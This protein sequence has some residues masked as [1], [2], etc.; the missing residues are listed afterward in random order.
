MKRRVVLNVVGLT[1]RDLVGAVMPRLSVWAGKHSVSKIRPAFPAVTCTAQANYL[2]GKTP[3]EH[4]IV[5]NGWHD[6]ALGEVHFWK[7]SNRLVNAPKVWDVL[8]AKHPGLRVANLFWW[9]NMGSTVDIAVTPRPIYRADGSKF[10][11]VASYPQSLK[12]GLKAALGEFPFH[13]FWGP[14]AGI[15]ATQWIADSARWVEEKEKPDLSFVYLP[16][17]DYDLQ[18]FGPADERS[19][20]A[21]REMDV[22]VCDLIEFFEGRGVEVTV[23][24]EYGITAVDRAVPLNRVLRGKGW[25]EIKEERGCEV[26]DYMASKA[27]AVVDH[28]VAHISVQ[29]PSILLQ[30]KAL[31]EATPGVG[32]VLDARSQEAAGI[33]HSRSG[34]LVAVADDH[35][36]F[37]YPWWED[38]SKAPDYARTVDIHR[39]PGYDPCELFLDPTLPMPVLKIA[40]FLLKKKLGFKG[41][42]EVIP[43][44]ASLVRGSHGRVPEDTLDWPVLIGVGAESVGGEVASM[45]VFKVLVGS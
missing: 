26:L 13:T 6:R 31:L 1:A 28:Q 4:G 9:Y 45:E 35:S 7:Q 21:R 23:L 41:L 43:L 44:D 29:D 5:A 40:L 17:L 15:A 38:D 34:D 39:K 20:K 42:L 33:A 16:H 2:T 19:N 24:S 37:S 8:R 11:D 27:F 32:K 10:F 12:P 14:K 25:L 3:S 36:W 22:L 30:V 18:R